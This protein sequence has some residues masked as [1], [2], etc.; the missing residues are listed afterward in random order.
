MPD[1]KHRIRGLDGLR[2]IAVALVLVMHKTEYG[3]DSRMGFYGV[4]LFFL[5]SGYLIIGQL[6]AAQQRIE[7]G[8][9]SRLSELLSFWRRRALRIF[10]AYYAVLIL[11]SFYYVLSSRELH[12]TIYYALHLSN[13]YLSHNMEQ[14]HTTWAHFW[15]LAVEE[16]FYLLAAPLLLLTARRSALPLCLLIIAVSCLQRIILTAQ[17]VD[18]FRIYIDSFVNVGLLAAGGALYLLF[19]RLGPWMVHAG[20]DRG[21]AGW[22]ALAV[23]LVLSATTTPLLSA[24]PVALQLSYVI[25]GAVALFVLANVISGQTNSLVSVLELSA[26]AAMGRLS[27]A[28]YL[29]ND[30]VPSDIPQRLAAI[31]ARHGVLASDWSTAAL[32]PYVSAMVTAGSLILCLVIVIC[33]AVALSWA[34]ERPFLQL[35]DQ[36]RLQR[37]KSHTTAGLVRPGSVVGVTPETQ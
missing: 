30:Y 1:A 21:P 12:G 10:P 6:H 35:R 14:F 9:S 19:D 29:I 23:F 32:P 3:T 37:S 17:G 26:I 8:R 15:S 27:Y 28:I 13:I 2:A 31:A 36:S 16:Q 5:L 33:A 25:G 18:P 24:H 20:L 7:A 4:W 34:V 11:I 22:T